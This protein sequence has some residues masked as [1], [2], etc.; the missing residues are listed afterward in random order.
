MENEEKK[1]DEKN[2]PRT[3]TVQ[4]VLF[5]ILI[6]VIA[7]QI[8]AA[9]QKRD[10]SIIACE[11]GNIQRDVTYDFLK[12]AAN[13][14]FNEAKLSDDQEERQSNLTAAREYELGADRLVAAA[15]K[16]PQRQGSPLVDCNAAVDYPFPINLFTSS[17]NL[18][19]EG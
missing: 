19:S 8:A 7:F 9:F 14:R 1:N 17:I 18:H 10:E 3:V 15:A 13:A 5:L 2:L 12:A 4:T 11:R 6:P 16:Y